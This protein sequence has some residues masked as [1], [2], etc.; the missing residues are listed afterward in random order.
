[1]CLSTIIDWAQEVFVVNGLSHNKTVL[2]ESFGFPLVEAMGARLPI[3]AAD[4]PVNQEVC[5]KA[6]IY[7]P[8]S[9]E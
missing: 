1:V 9:A 3:V 6:A 7:F 8:P 5:G 4:T 2:C